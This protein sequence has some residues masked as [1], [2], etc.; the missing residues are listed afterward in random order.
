VALDRQSIQRT[1]F[2]QGRRGYEPEAVAA[3]LE[4]I[5]DEVEELK[6]STGTSSTSLASSAGEQVRTIIDAA[7][8][9]A[10]QIRADADRDAKKVLADARSELRSARDQAA[11]EASDQVS[12]IAQSSTS[13]LERIDAMEQEIGKLVQTL[14][15]G[16][17]SLGGD[18]RELESKLRELE[19]AAV[20]AAEEAVPGEEAV[21]PA[22]AAVTPADAAVAAPA[23]AAQGGPDAVVEGEPVH[24]SRR[25]KLREQSEPVETTTAAASVEGGGREED[26][27][28]ARLIALNMAL[29]GNSR[30]DIDRYLQENF[31]LADREALLDEVTA[32]VEG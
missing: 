21:T 18:L 25:A 27:E 19:A 16:A 6:G 8:T 7:E 4:A 3:H 12:K 30:E 9:T 17:D 32:S 23:E 10:A 15:G 1:D 11:R 26:L 28:G 20:P 29:N 13:M 22:A 2:P 5:A 31:N 14:R 24:P